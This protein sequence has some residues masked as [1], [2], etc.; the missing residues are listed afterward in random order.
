MRNRG[1]LPRGAGLLL[2]VVL[3]SGPITGC[4]AAGPGAARTPAAV[5]PGGSEPAATTVVPRTPEPLTAATAEAAVPAVDLPNGSVP[6]AMVGSWTGGPGGKTG[7]YLLVAEDGRY[8]RGTA[9]D[10]PTDTGVIVVR[11]AA[12]VFLDQQGGR[13]RADL[14]Y[15]DAAGIEVLAVNYDRLGYFSYVR[16]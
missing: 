16:G 11:G 4:A 14:D 2:L 1:A 3:T 6:G 13:E 9:R 15:T 8:E 10:G 12:A 7:H 5:S